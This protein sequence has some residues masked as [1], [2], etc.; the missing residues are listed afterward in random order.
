MRKI[1]TSLTFFLLLL[2]Y[3]GKAQVI[4]GNGGNLNYSHSIYVQLW[5][6]FNDK[7]EPDETPKGDRK[8]ARRLVGEIGNGW[9]KI[10]GVDETEILSY[11]INDS[12]GC[13]VAS[14]GA[15][16]EFTEAL[17]SLSGE[18]EVRFHTESYVYVGYV[19]L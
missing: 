7:S 17:F 4:S 9:V 13:F 8:P 16:Y 6:S 10:E 11:E 5:P 15:P 14:F 12:D 19:E 18:Y 1:M 3:S 2:T